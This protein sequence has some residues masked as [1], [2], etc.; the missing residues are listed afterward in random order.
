LSGHKLGALSGV[1]AVVLAGAKYG[2]CLPFTPF[3][4]GGGQELGFRSGTENILG[5]TSL[6]AVVNELEEI[7]AEERKRVCALRDKLWARLSGRIAP[8]IRLTPE[9]SLGNTLLLQIPGCRTDDLVVSLDLKQV[10]TSRGSACSSGRQRPSHVLSAM[11]LSAAEAKSVLRIS[12]DWT[13]DEELLE[14]S[15]HKIE[16]AVTDMRSVYAAL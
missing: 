15:A 4:E 14:I 5:I 8:I 10:N 13:I 6:A 9:N 12:L 7:G 11:G 3:L 16:S 1:G 2:L